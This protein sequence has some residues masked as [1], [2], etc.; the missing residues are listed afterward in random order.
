MA[1]PV[2]GSHVKMA[3]TENIVHLGSHNWSPGAFSSQ[4]QDFVAIESQAFSALLAQQFEWQ[5]N[6]AEG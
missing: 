4:T 6:R 2:R 3:I 5:W 1:N